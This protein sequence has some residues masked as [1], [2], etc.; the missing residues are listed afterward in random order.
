MT[1]KPRLAILLST[2][3]GGKFLAEQLD[4]LFAQSYTNFVVVVRDDGSSDNTL[5]ILQDYPGAWAN[6]P[7]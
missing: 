7:A 6:S 3:N 4:S 2:W 1:D 5:A